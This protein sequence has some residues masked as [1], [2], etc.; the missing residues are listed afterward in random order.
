M[1]IILSNWR[2]VEK[3]KNI[4]DNSVSSYK[5]KMLINK[6][7]IEKMN[8]DI[9]NVTNNRFLYDYLAIANLD[10]IS[11]MEKLNNN[12]SSVKEEV[13]NIA[14]KRIAELKEQERKLLEEKNSGDAL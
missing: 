11:K 13:D 2:E 5:S 14:N 9:N 6:Q 8:S 3:D 10:L 7:Q 4:F 12:L 1:V